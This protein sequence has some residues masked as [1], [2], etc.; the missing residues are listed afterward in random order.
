TM[1][2]YNHL[3]AMAA[4]EIGRPVRIAL[5]RKGVFRIVGGRTPSR[6]RVGLAAAA[7]GAF[8]AFIHEGV[9]AQ[10]MD[11]NFPEQFS[12]PPR[13]LYAMQSYR[14]GPQGTAGKDGKSG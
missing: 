12:F 8:T 11:N 14:I 1:W 10:S 13:H 3:C 9:T 2:F 4:R 6:Q 7:K 5:S